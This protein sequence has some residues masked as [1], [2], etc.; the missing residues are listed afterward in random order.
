MYEKCFF[1][2][3]RSGSKGLPNKNISKLNDKMLF[4]WSFLSA[5]AHAE[6]KDCIIISTNCEIIKKWFYDNCNI[7]NNVYL[8][9]RPIDLC[10]DKNST[11][12]AMIDSFKYMEKNGHVI[13]NFVLLQPT[14][15]FRTDNIISKCVSY[16]YD[17][18]ENS[19]V[20]TGSKHTPFF[21]KN[22]DGLFHPVY[23]ISDRKM[24]QDIMDKDFYY[25]E[26]G[27]VY[28]FSADNLLY[29]SNR[30][31]EKCLIVENSFINSIQID[32]M[33]DFDMCV[34]IAKKERVLSW[35]NAL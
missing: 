6:K 24:R 14:S 20:F 32:T 3:A 11:E 7:F 27:N 33:E 35:M 30:L 10:G 28:V 8:R 22:I 13:K 1:I 25:H 31:T 15:P 12:S 5:R 4:E 19:T 29:N 16:F 26:D 2:P 18:G 23:K 34:G 9:D 17:N 21:W